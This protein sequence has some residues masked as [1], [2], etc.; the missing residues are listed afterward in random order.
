MNLNE[1]FVIACCLDND[2]YARKFKLFLKDYSEMAVTM[3]N[4]VQYLKQT[5]STNFVEIYQMYGKETVL[6]AMRLT[7]WAA[8]HNFNMRYNR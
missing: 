3:R 2:D 4:L 6:E 7:N 8:K 1:S 5:E